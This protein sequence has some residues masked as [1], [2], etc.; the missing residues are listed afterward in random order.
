MRKSLLSLLLLVLSVGLTW[1]QKQ[2]AVTGIVVAA[3]NNEPIEGASVICVEH[4]RSGALTDAKGKFT[5]RLPEGAKTL[6]ISYIGY[7]AETVAVELRV[8]LK[9]TE[10]TLD[11]LV[12]SAYGVQRKSSLTGATSSIKAADLANAKVESIDKAL[13]GKVSGIRVA[14]QTGNPGSAGTVQIRGVGSIN[15]TTEPLY[16]V[17]GVPVTTGNYG[18]GGY[19]SNILGFTLRLTCC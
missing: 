8:Q 17:D 1:A 10:K 12:V 4:P 3:E 5:L 6:R 11:P 16:V 14:S 19:S 9:S 18:I 7:G 15:G 2:V 13:S